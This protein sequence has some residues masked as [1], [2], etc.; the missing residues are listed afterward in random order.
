M[1]TY[2]VTFKVESRFW[3]LFE[4][5]IYPVCIVDFAVSTPVVFQKLL[6][7]TQSRAPH[8]ST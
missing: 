1:K 6:Y 3:L 2:Y 8:P 4:W 7:Y 5:C